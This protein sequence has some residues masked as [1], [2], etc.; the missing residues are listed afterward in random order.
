L[1]GNSVFFTA[2]GSEFVLETARF[3]RVVTLSFLSI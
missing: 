1:I 2:E 3:S